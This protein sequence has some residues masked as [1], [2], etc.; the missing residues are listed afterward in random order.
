MRKTKNNK[1]H[2]LPIKDQ[3]G[4][5]Y[6]VPLEGSLG[7]LAAGYKGLMMWREKKKQHMNDVLDQKLG[8]NQKPDQQ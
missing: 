4:N 3:D 1:S 8:I 5:E 6:E 7:L 2:Q